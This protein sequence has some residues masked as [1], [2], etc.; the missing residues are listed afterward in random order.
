MARS[1]RGVPSHGRSRC[2]DADA[3]LVVFFE[4]RIGCIKILKQ[5][6]VRVLYQALREEST[7][8][9]RAHL[10]TSVLQEGQWGT[11]LR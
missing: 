10:E 2:P 6:L 3:V 5:W 11:H 7:E 8:L 4:G 9:T 1:T